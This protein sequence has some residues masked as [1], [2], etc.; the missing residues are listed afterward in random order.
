V[1]VIVTLRTGFLPEGELGSAQG[2]ETQRASIAGA[3]AAVIQALSGTQ[4]AVRTFKSIPVMALRADAAALA[5]LRA[6]PWVESIEEDIPEPVML[7]ES[8]PLVGSAGA[9]GTSAAG[10]TGAG[11]TVVV[12]DSGVDKNHPF[13]AGRVV[14][15][16]CF[17]NASGTNVSLCPSGEATMLGSGAGASCT[18]PGCDHGTHVA[19]IAAGKAYSGLSFS[20]VAPEANIIAIQVFTRFN[21]SV[22]CQGAP[23]CIATFPSD[24][25]AALDYINT[26]L[27][28]SYN[29][30]AVNM[31]LGGT[32]TFS[33]ACDASQSGRKIAIDNLRSVNIATVIASGNSSSSTGISAPACISSAISVGSTLDGGSGGIPVDTVSSFSNSASYL[34]LLG[35]GQLINSSIPGS[36]FDDFSGTSMATPHVA[37]AWAV[38]KQAAPTA[39]VDTVLQALQN[40]GVS[41]TDS[42]NGITK[43]RIQLNGAL[44]VLTPLARFTNANPFTFSEGVDLTGVQTL[45]LVNVMGIATTLSNPSLTGS[46][47]IKYLG[48]S[49]P[50]TG[51]TCGGSLG[52]G[53]ACTIK[54]SFAP[55]STTPV[56]GTFTV[57]YR[58]LVNVQR[59]VS[60]ALSGVGTNVCP[61]NLLNNSRLEKQ[62]SWTQGASLGEGALPLCTTENCS[63]SPSFGGPAGPYS[64][65][66]WG[67]FGGITT[68]LPITRQTQIMTQTVNIPSGT[69]S[70]Q[71]NLHI[72]RADP[73]TGPTDRF[74]AL[75][76]NTPVFTATA[77]EA[78]LYPSFQLVRLNV[79]AFAGQAATLVFSAT[80]TTTGPIVNFNLDDPALCA[81]AYYP[82]YFPTISK[83]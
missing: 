8:T 27:R 20:G 48:G 46:A 6:S 70:L 57:T 47:T 51:G 73:G 80:T 26:T 40:T 16:A 79:G 54:L 2:V 52:A 21:D 42:R 37:G 39:S 69:A 81:P 71:F 41:V 13:L 14:T 66:G 59:Q 24:Q 9:P 56:S 34:S 25:I 11:W 72:S 7:A 74:R 43:K 1:N 78:S 10:Y 64:G 65:I 28:W 32:Q 4:A 15:E 3:Q 68:T 22:S 82:I 35:P 77:A 44:S 75:I 30:A 36:S 50:G 62:T 76:N 5:A 61:G 53:Q 38:L 83:N 18:I 45:T 33:S 63:T 58:D 12:L 19:G 31:S 67:W 29:I 49:Y 23:P 17:S 55:T 60:L